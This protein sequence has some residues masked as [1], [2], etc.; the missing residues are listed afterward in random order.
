MRKRVRIGV[1][2]AVAAV[3][4]A[5]FVV[6]P[7][8]TRLLPNAHAQVVPSPF[9]S[10]VPTILPST[11]PSPSPSPSDDSGGGS[12]KGGSGKGGDTGSGGSGGG[13][14]PD[15]GG[16]GAPSGGSGSPAGSERSHRRSTGGG[17]PG[18]SVTPA[19]Y[20]PGGSFSTAKLVAIAAE[21]RA[22]GW[23]EV[24]IRDKVYAPFIL[25]GKAAW[26]DTWGAPRYGPAPGQI[27][28]HEGQDV[29][30][31]YGEPVLAAARGSIEFDSGG[32]GGRVAR[33][34]LA[35]G[36]Y[37]YYAHLS[38]WNTERFH[39]GDRVRPGDVIGYCGTPAT[40]SRARRTCTSRTTTGMS[41]HTTR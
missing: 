37:W 2:L 15:S 38:G 39:D 13:A 16:S 26:V 35:N 9:P 12:G 6:S 19:F 34:H 28:S 29:F 40:Q 24:A 23:S 8:P 10:I 22:L 7:P 21:L 36:W 4:V 18:R 14:A 31:Q 5:A 25:A 20:S 1:S 17:S 32:L 11:G 30:C 41:E 27:R 3:F 33:L